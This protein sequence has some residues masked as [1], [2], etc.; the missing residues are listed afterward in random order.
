M[1]AEGADELDPPY[2]SDAR[3]DALVDEVQLLHEIREGLEIEPRTAV[4]LQA[5]TGLIEDRQAE[6]ERSRRSRE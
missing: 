6:L 4:I 3:I 2:E 5:V 1:A